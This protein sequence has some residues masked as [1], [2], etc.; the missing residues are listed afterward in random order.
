MKVLMFSALAKVEY[1]K[2]LPL[3]GLL[4]QMNL[5]TLKPDHGHG[6]KQTYIYQTKRGTY[7]NHSNCQIHSKASVIFNATR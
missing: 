3:E 6:G 4:I 1:F 2:H 7:T 5:L